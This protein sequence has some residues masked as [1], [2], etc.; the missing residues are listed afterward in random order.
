MASAAA[1]SGQDG[2]EGGAAPQGPEWFSDP[3]RLPVQEQEVGHMVEGGSLTEVWTAVDGTGP[4]P[5]VWRCSSLLVLVD[6]VVLV[7]SVYL[8]Q[9]G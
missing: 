1:P 7:F 5:P 9:S 4:R 6:R 3:G 2:A 8:N